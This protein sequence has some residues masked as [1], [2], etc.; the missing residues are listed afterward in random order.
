[1]IGAG[2]VGMNA[3]QGARVCGAAEILAVDP[4]AGRREQAPRYGATATATPDDLTDLVADAPR[5]GLDWAIVTVGSGDAMRLG[6]DLVRPGGVCCVVG[7]APQGRPVGIDML[8][9]VTYERHIVGSAY[10]S[11]TPQRLVPRILALYLDGRLLLDELVSERLPLERINEAFDHSR[12]AQ[13]MRPVLLPDGAA[14][15]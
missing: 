6:V 1:V 14:G 11:I 2:G 3:I 4:A 8:D 5:S 9:L 10:G 7:L 12:R 15:W 13:G